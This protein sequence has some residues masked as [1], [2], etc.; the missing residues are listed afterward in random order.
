MIPSFRFPNAMSLG[1]LLWSVVPFSS[2]GLAADREMV[3]AGLLTD[4]R[5][6]GVQVGDCD[7]NSLS[8]RDF[9]RVTAVCGSPGGIDDGAPE[10]RIR[11]IVSPHVPNANRTGF[12]NKAKR[13]LS[14]EK[15]Q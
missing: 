13:L 8:E 7:L 5:T 9:R 4:M 3:C 6:I 1:I 15:G 2:V 12:I 14:V 11:A 10:C